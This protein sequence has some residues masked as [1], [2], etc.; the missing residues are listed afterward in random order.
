MMLMMGLKM[1]WYWAGNISPSPSLLFVISSYFILPPLHKKKNSSYVYFQLSLLYWYLLCGCV[2]LCGF[3]LENVYPGIFSVPLSPPSSP[4]LISP[5][6]PLHPSFQTEP[7]ILFLTL[8]LWGLSMVSLGIFLS[9]FFSSSRTA[10]I[11]GFVLF[12]LYLCLLVYIF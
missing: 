5:L 9:A 4:F 1:R 2:P 10:S 8:L 11:A 6:P 12:C 7:M 3:Q